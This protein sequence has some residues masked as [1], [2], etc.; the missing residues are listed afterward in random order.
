MDRQPERRIIP[1]PTTSVGISVFSDHLL[2]T[3]VILDNGSPIATTAWIRK[4][5]FDEAI[6]IGKNI[7]IA[8]ALDRL[9]LSCGTARFILSVEDDW[10]FNEAAPRGIIGESM[11]EIEWHVRDVRHV[12]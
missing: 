5:K 4:Q 3:T 11:R 6:F 10:I 7:G 12:E 2:L 1:A 8:R 9:W